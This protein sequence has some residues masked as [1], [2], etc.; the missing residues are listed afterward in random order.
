LSVLMV[1]LGLAFAFAMSR[2]SGEVSG[3]T[4]R[5]TADGHPDFTG[6]WQ[7][8]N[9]AAWDL[10]DHTGRL[11]VPAGQGVVEGGEIPYLPAALK[12]RAEQAH[13]A[14]GDPL[15]T[16]TADPIS[17]CYMPGVPRVTYMPYPFHIVQSP[18]SLSIAYEF[19]RTSRQIYFDR[20]HTEGRLYNWMGD[21]V[22]H[23]DGDTL[24][25]DVVDFNDRTWFDASG[26]FH[27][28]QLHVVERYT[29]TG[30]DHFRYDVT[31]E[32][33]KVFARPWK[34]SMPIYRR[35]EPQAQILE[36]MCLE[37][38]EPLLYGER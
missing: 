2:P 26:N 12:Q 18:H 35:L 22:A 13:A 30:R 36:Y 31:I 3:E 5:R 14:Q 11:G 37:Y 17:R 24:V 25:I 38:K 34:I 32:D 9:T 29:P 10:E 8:M 4:I 21:S 20:P 27:S 6:V 7:V 28:D 16:L 19:A 23:W 1:V 15:R 33:A